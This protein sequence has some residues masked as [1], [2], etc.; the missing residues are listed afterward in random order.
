MCE[1]LH[2]SENFRCICRAK[3]ACRS[4]DWQSERVVSPRLTR[5][6]RYD[7]G[8]YRRRRSTASSDL[9][10][11]RLKPSRPSEQEV[12][13]AFCSR[14]YG[15]TALEKANSD[16]GSAWRLRQAKPRL[17]PA[18]GNVCWRSAPVSLGLSPSCEGQRAHHEQKHDPRTA[19]WPSARQCQMTEGVQAPLIQVNCPIEGT[20]SVIPLYFPGAENHL[21]RPLQSLRKPRSSCLE[22]RTGWSSRCFRVNARGAVHSSIRLRRPCRVAGVTVLH[23][24]IA[25]HRLACCAR[26]DLTLRSCVASR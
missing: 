7:Q 9:Y 6:T 14:K 3:A 25:E 21:F 17:L 10:E 8:D 24:S 20:T 22:E 15:I 12:I 13:L 18:A 1:L 26:N 23:W 11:A 19:S 5:A 4:R 2:I 16:K